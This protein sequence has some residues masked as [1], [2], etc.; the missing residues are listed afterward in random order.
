M[1]FC[2]LG[3]ARQAHPEDFLRKRVFC[4][5]KS[6]N[7]K[8]RLFNGNFGQKEQKCSVSSSP[9]HSGHLLWL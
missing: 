7:V 1:V 4:V 3:N 5:N 9:T 6:H 2:A 8:K